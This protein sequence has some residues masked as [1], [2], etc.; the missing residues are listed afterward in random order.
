MERISSAPLI[1]V[2]TVAY[3]AE[4]T[5]EKTILSVIQQTYSN[6]EYIIIDG[7]SSDNTITIVKKYENYLSYWISES[8]KG[9]YDAMNKGIKKANGEWICFMNSGDTFHSPDVLNKIFTLAYYDQN[10]GVI[11]GD[12][13]LYKNNQFM[14][15]FQN[16]PFWKSCMPYRTGKGICHQSMFTRTVLAKKLLFN[17]EYKISADFDMAYK[18]YKLKF[19]FQY[20]NVVVCNFDI[21]GMSSSGKYWKTTFQET[22]KILNCQYN[23]GYWT[24]FLYKLLKMYFLSR[25]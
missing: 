12:A 11:Y 3:N 15:P 13:Y 17:L 8:D 1:S 23:L 6:I 24:F 5:I 14:M 2:I 20:V 16:Q 18:I 9:V 19:Q 7:K 10:I 4:T 25:K 21:D 22:G